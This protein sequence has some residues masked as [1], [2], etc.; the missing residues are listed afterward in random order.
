MKIKVCQGRDR[1]CGS[2]GVPREG[3]WRRDHPFLPGGWGGELPARLPAP[4]DTHGSVPPR[5]PPAPSIHR[6]AKLGAPGSLA[7]MPPPLLLF[8]L[9][10]L[11]PEGVRPQKTLLVEAKGTSKG[12]RWKEL[13][14]ETWA[15]QGALDQVTILS[16]P[17]FYYP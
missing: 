14:L 15:C 11:T 12:Y 3:D 1:F 7:A 2:G 16:G 8:F 17:S 10:F 4:T 13:G 9:L 6:A 5:P